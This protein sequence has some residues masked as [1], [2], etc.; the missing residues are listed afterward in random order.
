MKTTVILAECKD[1]G[2]INEE[3][4]INLKRVADSFPKER[5]ETFIVLSK[6]PPFT[7]DEIEIS[8]MLN[9][10]YKRRVI[11]LTAKELEP[12]H[13]REASK[14]I[15]DKRLRWNSPKEMAD[16]TFELYFMDDEKD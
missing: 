2:P 6:I 9:D 16:S 12:Y 4:V 14:E 15:T 10:E 5:F 13:I 7:K 8:K 1:V 3:D 11:L